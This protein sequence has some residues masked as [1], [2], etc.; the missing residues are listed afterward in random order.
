LNDREESNARRI[1]RT[2][3]KNSPRGNLV[4]SEGPRD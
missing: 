3:E 1:T 2:K 4:D